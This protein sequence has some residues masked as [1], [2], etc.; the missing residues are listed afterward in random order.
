MRARRIYVV[1]DGSIVE[2]GTHDELLAR[3]GLYS[4]LYEI[5]FKGQEQLSDLK[6]VGD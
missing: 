3:G 1:E 6:A 2:S 5:Q 4:R